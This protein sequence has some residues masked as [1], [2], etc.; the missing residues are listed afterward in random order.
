MC[1]LKENQLLEDICAKLNQIISEKKAKRLKSFFDQSLLSKYISIIEALD[2][3]AQPKVEVNWEDNLKPILN[4]NST[5]TPE[6]IKN[7]VNNLNFRKLSFIFPLGGTSL[8]KRLILSNNIFIDSIKSIK[9]NSYNLNLIPYDRQDFE[10]L[11]SHNI[12]AIFVTEIS[13]EKHDFFTSEQVKNEVQK[14]IALLNINRKFIFLRHNRNRYRLI[15][16]QEYNSISMGENVCQFKVEDKQLQSNRFFFYDGRFDKDL[17]SMQQAGNIDKNAVKKQFEELIFKKENN[18][19]AK[20]ILNVISLLE[21]SLVDQNEDMAFL[22]LIIALD[23]LLERD[24]DKDSR[25]V[26]I[27]LSE[28][29]VFILN[30]G[31]SSNQSKQILKE[32]SNG[33]DQRSLLVHEGLSIKNEEGIEKTYQFLFNLLKRV[34]NALILDKRFKDVASMA[35]VFKLIDEQIFLERKM[36]AYS[37]LSVLLDESKEKDKCTE[38]I[39]FHDLNKKVRNFI[40]SELK[41][42]KIINFQMFNPNFTKKDLEFVLNKLIK[43]ELVLVINSKTYKLSNTVKNIEEIKYEEIFY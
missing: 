31:I 37:I 36:I 1:I 28:N 5:I 23:A 4:N 24:N 17:F 2:T 14:I 38:Y 11:L 18:K 27:Q 21:G 26:R 7:M 8:D 9:L 16:R 25:R 40:N 39:N 42:S 30:T 6:I 13:E 41:Q 19:K 33:Y 10:R 12:S 43:N 29:I 22:K 35:D 3:Y 20:A 15:S 34:I 32:I